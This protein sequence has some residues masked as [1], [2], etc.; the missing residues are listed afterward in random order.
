MKKKIRYIV[1][2]VVVI[3]GG[4]IVLRS[5]Q[6]AGQQ[7]ELETERVTRGEINEV[8]TAT[9]TL[10]A[11]ETVEVGTQVSGVIEKIYVDYNSQVKKGQLLAKLDQTPLIAQLDQSKA[12]VDQAEAELQ[13]Q[14]ATY[15]RYKKLIDKKLIAQ[16]DYDL[17]EYNYNKAVAS[18]NNARS[19][20]DKNK[21]NLSYA[22]IYSPIDGIILDRAVD[23]G[24]TVAASFNTPTLFTIA[25]DLTQMQVEA[26]VDEADIGYLKVGQR[27]DFT[28]DAYPDEKFD[29][30]ITQIRLNPVETSNV[31]TYTVVVDAPNPDKKLMPGMTAN[32][33]FYVTEKKNILLMPARAL[34]FNPESQEWTAFVESH[35]EI[36][37]ENPTSNTMFQEKIQN[38]GTALQKE[39]TIW[40]KDG[41]K[42][43]T[44]QVKLGDTNEL[45][46]EVISG[47]Q[48]GDEVIISLES[49]AP[50]LSDAE[51]SRSP[52][53]PKP[54]SS[55]RK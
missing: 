6:K 49:D 36:T 7:M 34:N 27:V 9:G 50:M 28:V 16:S 17:A 53:M 32:V 54:P 18:L 10:E 21:I 33:S 14:K 45:F 24:Q 3:T 19:V 51:G 22:T 30:E 12:T 11:L 47:L 46:Y 15:E 13:Y 20:Y 55:K 44:Q 52:F 2:A 35:P 37:L 26:D 43:K 40:V 29:G 39:K 42:I 5:F 1:L 38:Q 23:E 4:L 41:N 25:N 31:I 48:E 8:I